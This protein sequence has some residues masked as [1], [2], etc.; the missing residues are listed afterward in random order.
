MS[1][2]LRILEGYGVVNLYI[3]KNFAKSNQ[4]RHIGPYQPQLGHNNPSQTTATP[5]EP[6]HPQ[7]GHTI[8]NRA[9]PTPVR[10]H[11]PK[12]GHTDPN[13]VRPP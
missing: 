4:T 7:P 1:T 8:P 5:A 11:H 12:P 13:R 2:R 6:H 3:I 9:T 10:P